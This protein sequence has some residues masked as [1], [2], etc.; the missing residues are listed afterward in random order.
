MKKI[1]LI[2]FIFFFSSCYSQKSYFSVDA[3]MNL[4]HLRISL[5]NPYN[6]VR[7]KVA[8]ENI[9]RPTGGL[10]YQ[11]N[12]SDLFALRI[13]ARYFGLGSATKG[14]PDLNLNYLSTPI[15]FNYSINSNFNA[16]AGAYF[17]FLLNDD[18]YFGLPIHLRF[19]KNDF[20]TV[21][22]L[23]HKLYKNFSIGAHYYL[24]LKNIYLYD[25][26]VDSQGGTWTTKYTNRVFQFS[27]IYK[28]RRHN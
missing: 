11:F 21:L 3:G 20:G 13:G 15:C 25:K 22:G 10:F 23:E 24:G 14:Q 19:S 26:R 28:F 16:S 18:S 6:P 4:A 27:I 17:S 9:I 8:L 12:L 5:E 7:E 1:F 2:A